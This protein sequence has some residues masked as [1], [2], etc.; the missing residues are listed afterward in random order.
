MD[1]KIV[2]SDIDGTVLNSEHRLLSSTIKSV[3]ILASKNIPFVLV[4]ARMP[5]AMKL[6]V[7]E[8]KVKMPMISYGGALVLDEQN[9]ILYDNKINKVDTKAIIDEIESLKSEKI[10]V[11]YY[12]NDNWY[13]KDKDNLAVKIEE[14]ITNVKASQVDFKEL[15]NKDILPN[16]I[17]CMTKVNSSSRIEC[18]L[19]EKF[20]Q[21]NVVRSSNILLE[22]MNK[23]VSKANGLKVL[24]DYLQIKSSQAVAFGD[25]YND[26]DMLKFV[27]RGVVMQNAPEE[28]KKQMK[29]ITKSNNKDGIYEYLKKLDLV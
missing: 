10:V 24:L 3:Q 29:Y 20:P 13:V 8:M 27:G 2:F 18:M 25:N 17:L 6:I 4:S 22:I 21:L 5:T 23:D 28:I 12:S 11:N 1:W 16:K 26:L 7:D 19:K 14:S 9:H 15:I